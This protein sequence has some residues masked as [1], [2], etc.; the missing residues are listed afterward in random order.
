M[1]RKWGCGGPGGPFLA[2]RGDDHPP[3]CHH[4]PIH[5]S[6]HHRHGLWGDLHLGGGWGQDRPGGRGRGQRWG[7]WVDRGSG[8]EGQQG[9]QGLTQFGQS[10][11]QG[12]GQLPDGVGRL[13][14]RPQEV[15]GG[16]RA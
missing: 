1:G 3:G 10:L 12:A 5:D 6:S 13:L 2:S 4:G 9:A 11:P 14:L 15:Q 16:V 8:Q 7:Q